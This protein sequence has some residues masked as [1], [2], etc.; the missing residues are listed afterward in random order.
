MLFLL[1]R[2]LD[3]GI[4]KVLI[5]YLRQLA[6]NETYQLSLAIGVDMGDLEVFAADVPE[7]VQVTHLVQARWLTRWLCQKRKKRLP[8]LAKLWDGIF[9]AAIRRGLIAYRLKRL[10]AQHDV[11]IDF[12]T[13]F[14]S[15]LRK[16][17]VRKI[18]WFHF[19]FDEAM[20]QNRRRMLRIG[21]RLEQYDRV[22]CIA[23]SMRKECEKLFPKLKDRLCVI[24]NAKNREAILQ[25]AA[26]P[27]ADARIEAPYLIA[28]ERLEESQ[29]DVTTLLKAYQVLREKY[30]HTEKLYLLGKGHSEQQL[31][32]LAE[33]LGIADSVVFLGFYENPY[34]WIQHS[35][36]L[37]HSAKFEGLPTVLI[38]GLMLDKLIVATDCPTGPS[39]ILDQGHAGLL[40]P[41]G[42]VEAFAEA[43]HRALSDEV[44]QGTLLQQVQRHR[45]Q[46]LFSHT[47]VLFKKL[48]TNEE[49][50]SKRL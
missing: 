48:I 6:P 43:M 46:F 3:G 9:L 10:A 36:L 47:E 2:F 41:V 29:K 26:E 15:F 38:E 32:M 19:S 23:E 49:N 5:D 34:P 4:D 12:D 14:Y 17:P 37:V 45:Q 31:R 50:G 44:L 24:Y 18:A 30:G 20:K 11:V 35:R 22:V 1:S 16:N 42:D 25:R 21:R 39:E 33:Q 13:C 40:V 8:L 7:Q 27:V 28:V